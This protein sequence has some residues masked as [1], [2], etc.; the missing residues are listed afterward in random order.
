MTNS[1]RSPGR[2]GS[3]PD[4]FRSHH[5]MRSGFPSICSGLPGRSHRSRIS[6]TRQLMP[7]WRCSTL[8]GS[9]SRPSRAWLNLTPDPA[10]GRHRVEAG[11]QPRLE[12]QQPGRRSRHLRHQRLGGRL[13]PPER[14]RQSTIA[15][16]VWC[17]PRRDYA[18]HRASSTDAITLRGAEG[19]GERVSKHQALP[20]SCDCGSLVSG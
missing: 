14:R 7:S 3:G 12:T 10:L 6:V 17:P 4:T 8:L 5:L 18:P 19:Q 2:P 11:T 9:R 20:H 16:T 1:P 13:R 15:R